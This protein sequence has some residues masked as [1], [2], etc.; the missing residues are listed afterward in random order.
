MPAH[1]SRP[2]VLTLGGMLTQAK[3]SKVDAPL[4]R[5]CPSLAS[6]LNLFA[7]PSNAYIHCEEQHSAKALHPNSTISSGF[8][9]HEQQA[10]LDGWASFK[11]FLRWQDHTAILED[12][13]VCRA[14][15]C[16]SQIGSSRCV[17]VAVCRKSME[18]PKTS[19]SVTE[20]RLSMTWSSRSSNRSNFAALRETFFFHEYGRRVGMVPRS[21]LKG[22]KNSLMVEKITRTTNTNQK[23]QQK[24]QSRVT[25]IM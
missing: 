20:A 21:S 1:W 8:M 25:T 11:L 12:N 16:L 4:K 17:C 24:A 6:L 15:L 10:E 5:W 2:A 14:L 9:G 23:P 3:L 13:G 19:R 7:I 18:H 22:G